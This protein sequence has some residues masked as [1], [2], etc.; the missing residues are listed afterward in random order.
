MAFLFISFVANAQ[1]ISVTSGNQ[2][3]DTTPIYGTL[4]W[5]VDEAISASDNGAIP[6]TITIDATTVS[7]IT[8]TGNH[9]IISNLDLTIQVKGTVTITNNNTTAG[10]YARVF[11][12]DGSNSKLTVNGDGL[13][14]QNSKTAMYGSAVTIGGGASFVAINTTFSNNEAVPT[15]G[16]SYGGAVSVGSGSF[17]TAINTTFYKNKANAGDGG[18]VFV[19]P[20]GRAYFYHCTFIENDADMQNAGVQNA[21]GGSVAVSINTMFAA[22][23]CIFVGNTVGGTATAT[24]QFNATNVVGTN[25]VQSGDNTLLTVFG[26]APPTPINNKFEPLCITTTAL[27]NTIQTATGVTAAFVLQHLAKD[28]AGNSRSNTGNVTFGAV[29][30]QQTFTLTVASDDA[31]MGT[32]SGGGTFACGSSHTITATPEEGYKFSHWMQG[33]VEVSSSAEFTF[34]LVED[35]ELTAVFEVRKITRIKKI[36]VKKGRLIITPQP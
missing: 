23:N 36:N 9:I 12:V 17:F 28:Q 4:R 13:V 29:E 20:N 21:E 1:P 15:F 27:T 6:Q 7:A 30:N 34:N 14:F 3:D 16:F 19:G 35:T 33:G 18:A 24:N 8:L 5:A 25:L 22:Y 11:N 32:V 10:T 26:D 31:T 2:D